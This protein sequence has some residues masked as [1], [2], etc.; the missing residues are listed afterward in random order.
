MVYEEPIQLFVVFFSGTLVELITFWLEEDQPCSIEE[1]VLYYQQMFIN[2]A[3]NTLKLAVN[4]KIY[5]N[6]DMKG[7]IC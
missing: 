4:M 7:L 1:M 2:S 6:N 3:H 5:G